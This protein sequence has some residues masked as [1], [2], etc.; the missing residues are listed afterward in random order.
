[1]VRLTGEFDAFTADLV[2]A[3]TVVSLRGIADVRLDLEQ[4]TFCDAWGCGLPREF[5]RQDAQAD[6][7]SGFSVLL[8]PIC[9]GCS[10]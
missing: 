5:R 7:P 1:L 4:L 8:T 3:P 6:E 10:G 2:E 9:C